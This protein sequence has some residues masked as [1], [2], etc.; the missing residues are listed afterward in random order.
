M[1]MYVWV[2]RAARCSLR[3]LV[4]SPAF[5]INYGAKLSVRMVLLSVCA[6]CTSCVFYVFLLHYL[7]TVYHCN[8]IPI[9]THT[10]TQS[11]SDIEHKTLAN[12]KLRER[13][14][15]Y[16][17]SM[18]VNFCNATTLYWC[19]AI[20]NINP[21]NGTRERVNAAAAA[22]AGADIAHPL[23]FVCFDFCLL[24]SLFGTQSFSLFI[25][26]LINRSQQ[27]HKSNQ[28]HRQ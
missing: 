27:Q 20:N 4:Y 6:M 3:L 23:S 15:V 9:H 13:N 22:D 28:Q 21:E 17:R 25:C 11:L 10:H 24:Y 18:F 19:S 26:A 5:S 12:W 2:E 16:T 1:C 14:C 7:S 8:N